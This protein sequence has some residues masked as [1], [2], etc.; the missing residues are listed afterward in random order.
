LDLIN[1]LGKVFLLGHAG[2]FST[3]IEGHRSKMA[4][5]A[6]FRGCFAKLNQIAAHSLLYQY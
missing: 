4:K 3:I 5:M 1:P 2:E 6:E